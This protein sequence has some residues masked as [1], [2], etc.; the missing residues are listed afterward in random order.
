[1][2]EKFIN[3]SL[4]IDTF[5]GIT[6]LL[7]L[8]VNNVAIDA[9]TPYYLK[10]ATWGGGVTLADLVMPWFLMIVGMSIPFSISSSR[11]RGVPLWRYNLKALKRT[12]N[13]FLLG[14]FLTSSVYKQP[15]L[16]ME[17]LQLIGLAYFVGVI[18]CPLPILYRTS[19]A[20]LFLVL[21]WAMIKFVPIP[22][23][24]PGTFT[25]DRN[26]IKYIDITYL[27][28]FHLN[29][30]VSVIPT[31]AL[32]IIGSIIGTI[33][34]KREIRKKLIIFF[35]IGVLLILSGLAWNL[36][37][38]FNKPYWTS[39]YVLY[40]VGLGIL[41]LDII[42]LVVEIIRWRRWTFP[43]VVLGRNAILAYIL[44][45]LFK[46][47]ILDGWTYRMPNGSVLSVKEAILHLLIIKFGLVIGGWS[48]TILY[49]LAFWLFFL[50]LYMRGI[51]I[52]IG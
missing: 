20:S 17:V 50:Y 51:F 52:K 42:Y 27:Q 31:S 2:N 10:H 16:G 47:Y 29:G 14:C 11:K 40:S 41:L 35:S 46:V 1:M 25:E 33:L 30:I 9:I 19:I 26:I 22:G 3:R 36:D 43:F 6:I 15:Y 23:V 4:P 28:K 13:L 24:R 34:M 21:H 37:I 39:S 49:I 12:I 44:P 48:F 32:V 8:L 45:I 38:P 7:M 5:R 18:F